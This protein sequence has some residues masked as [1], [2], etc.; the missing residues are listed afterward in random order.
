MPLAYI[1]AVLSAFGLVAAGFMLEQ[2][3]AIAIGSGFAMGLLV[4]FMEG[5]NWER[6][7]TEKYRALEG[8]PRDGV[9]W[10]HDPKQATVCK[11]GLSGAGF[12]W[13]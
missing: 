3:L 2:D 10:G 7:L 6:R 1:I 4:G 12:D 8:P 13:E 9:E 5:A 11:Y